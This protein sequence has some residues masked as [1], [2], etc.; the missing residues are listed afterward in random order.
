MLANY[1]YENLSLLTKLLLPCILLLISLAVA[2][3]I[4]S[5]LL[6]KKRLIE[7]AEKRLEQTQQLAYGEFKQMEQLLVEQ[8]LHIKSM[9]PATPAEIQQAL[10]VHDHHLSAI[11]SST[12][13]P[14]LPEPLKALAKKA[15]PRESAYVAVVTNQKQ[16]YS[17][18]ACLWLDTDRY[19]FLSHRLDRSCLNEIAERFKLNFYLLDRQGRLIAD[20]SAAK[21]HIPLLSATDLA[22]LRSGSSLSRIVDNG[23]QRLISYSPLPLGHEGIFLLGASQ[24]LSGLETLFLHHRLYLLG[25]TGLSLLICITLFRSLLIRFF[26]PLNALLAASDKVAN[27][28]RSVRVEVDRSNRSQ[29]NKLGS[30]WNQ[31]LDLQEEKEQ[32]LKLLS[33][34]LQNMD[35]LKNHNQYL[36]KTNLELETRTISL[37]EQNQEFT[38]LFQVTQTMVSSLDQRLLYE[39]IIQALKDSLHCTVCVLYI[40]HSGAENLTAVKVQGL[41]G[42]DLKSVSVDLGIGLAGE[43]ALSQ[44]LVYAPD[45]TA[46]ADKPRYGNESIT[47]G[48]LLSVPMTVQN[49][50]IGVINLH[51]NSKNAFSSTAQKVAQAIASQAAIAIENARLYEKTKTLSATDELTGLSNRRQFQEYL[52]RELAQSRRHHSPFSILMIDIDH[53]KLYNDFHGHLKGDIVLKRVASL[54]LQNTRG[55]DLVARFGGEEFVLLLP[56]S[57]KPSSL[58]VADKLRVCV[59]KD[60]FP[61]AEKSQPGQRL[62]ISIGVAHF[63]SDSTEIYD[64]MNLAD[65]ALYEAKR[66]GRNKCIAWSPALLPAEESTPPSAGE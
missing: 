2:T 41:Y 49:R 7:T 54:L 1:R 22:R 10:S 23:E 59:E 15:K 43:A 53:F 42:I 12:A 5:S 21:G 50:L 9:L 4:G 47:E 17:L 11:I 37:K 19:L 56:K 64:L 55:V 13:N 31:L 51:Q 60:H 63:P 8:A 24:S 45:L 44:K 32:Q 18:V 39:R 6:L 3:S 25:I 52:L 48:S 36:R 61:G 29:L 65:T 16:G 38:A 40:F 33:E 35:D 26:S 62:T 30:A 34:Q 20:N 58:A 14:D 66:Q 27:G 28:D 46:C 57:D